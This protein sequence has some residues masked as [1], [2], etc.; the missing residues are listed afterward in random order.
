MLDR[1]LLNVLG[2]SLEVDFD[3]IRVVDD[4]VMW[5]HGPD[6]AVPAQVRRPW[7]RHLKSG[8]EDRPRRVISRGFPWPWRR[9]RCCIREPR[10][11]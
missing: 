11:S 8:W 9:S 6:V 1:F 2:Y 7:I 3:R 5:G 4:D 10:Q